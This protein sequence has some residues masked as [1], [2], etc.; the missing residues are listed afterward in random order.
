MVLIIVFSLNTKGTVIKLLL[1]HELA[2]SDV[3]HPCFYSR[4]QCWQEGCIR[5]Y[6][7]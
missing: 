4:C 7:S 5:P 2:N 3:L 6:P 1:L